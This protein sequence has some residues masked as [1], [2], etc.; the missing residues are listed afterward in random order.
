MPF[1][2]INGHANKL[3]HGESAHESKKKM[4]D[5]AS[6]INEIKTIR[7]FE[8]TILFI[9]LFILYIF[10]FRPRRWNKMSLDHLAH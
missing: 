1:K 6:W 9:Y 2:P 4:G 8:F 3:P 5:E 10:F 7:D